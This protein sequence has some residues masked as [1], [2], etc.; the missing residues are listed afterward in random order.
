MID[1]GDNQVRGLLEE[2]VHADDDA[3]GGSA[4]D[5]PLIFGDGVADDGLAE[6]QGLRGAAAFPA[7]GHDADMG[8]IFQFY[9]DGPHSFREIAVIIGEQN[10][11]FFHGRQLYL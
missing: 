2:F 8:E 9:G 3:I 11:W 6:G 1:A 5:G 7:W 4:V 10:S